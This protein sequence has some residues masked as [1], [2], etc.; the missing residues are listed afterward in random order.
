V[1]AVDRSEAMTSVA[2]RRVPGN[3]RV[4]TGDVMELDLPAES[5]DVVTCLAVLHHLP[6]EA[7][8]IR[9]RTALRP[10]G[11]LVVLGVPAPGGPL[12]ALQ[13]CAARPADLVMG[14]SRLIGVRFLPPRM[15]GRLPAAVTPGLP[16]RDPDLSIREVRRRTRAIL[17]GARVRRLLFWRY[18]LVYRRPVIP[19]PVIRR[20]V[21]PG[22]VD[23]QLTR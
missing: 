2:R 19:R 20:Q 13:W 17:P 23:P 3:V 21:R 5:F 22:T 12:D 15:R 4:I 7:A 6:L 14:L 9:I 8:L 10:G 18:L 1:V 11:V 16:L